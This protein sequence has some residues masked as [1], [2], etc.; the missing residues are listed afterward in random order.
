M[1]IV[2]WCATYRRRVVKWSMLAVR[3]GALFSLAGHDLRAFGWLAW[4]ATEGG[5]C[6]SQVAGWGAVY[7]RGL[8]LAGRGQTPGPFGCTAWSMVRCATRL[9]QAVECNTLT[10]SH[11]LLAVRQRARHTGIGCPTSEAVE[12][13]SCVSQVAQWGDSSPWVG[14][15]SVGARGAGLLIAQCRRRCGM[16]CV[17]GRSRS[18]LRLR[19]PARLLPDVAGQ[20]LRA[21]G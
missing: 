7:G 10:V 5:S 19:G 13:G 2:T 6:E 12:G 16:L 3:R 15:V 21:F 8:F 4:G 1:Q 14:G 9:G 17:D 20:G 11:R 18:G